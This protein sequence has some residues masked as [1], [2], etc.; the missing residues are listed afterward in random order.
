MAKQKGIRAGRAFVEIFADNNKLIRGLRRARKRLIAFGKNIVNIASRVTAGISAIFVPL[1]VLTIKAAADAQESLSRF[2]AVFKNQAEA[3]K[4]FAD[5]LAEAVG[6]SKFDIIDALSTFQSFFVGLGFSN[7]G[8]LE[9][10]KQ[11][12]TL[13][14]DFASF[15][16]ITDDES[17]GRFISALSGSSEV[18]DR[19]GINIKQAAIQQELLRKGIEKSASQITEQEKAMARLGIITRAMGDQ[20][21]IG[22]AIRTAG[23]FTNQM[24]RLKG[25]IRDTSVAIGQALLPIVTP[26]LVKIT[27]I[28]KEFGKWIAANK[29]LVATLFKITAAIVT[30]GVGVILIGATIAG[31]GLLLGGVITAITSI[32][33]IMTT[34]ATAISFVLTP[35]GLVVIA[36]VALGV[37]IVTMTDVGAEALHWLGER[38]RKLQHNVGVV[39]NGIIDAFRGGDIQLAARIL[40]LGLR[41]VWEIGINELSTLWTKFK[42]F[43]IATFNA[44]LD[45]GE[46]AWLRFNNVLKMDMINLS[47]FIQSQW[48]N[49][50]T[51]LIELW[52]VFNNF[53]TKQW[54]SLFNLFGKLTDEQLKAAQALSDSETIQK[55][56]EIETKGTEKDREIEARLT[57]AQTTR[58][59][60]FENKLGRIGERNLKEL[61]RLDEQ[62]HKQRKDGEN[63]I[64]ALVLRLE[65]NLANARQKA[66]LA[67]EN[68]TDFASRFKEFREKLAGLGGGGSVTTK[69]GFATSGL[70]KF[71]G[72]DVVSRIVV[73]IEKIER[74]TKEIKDEGGITFSG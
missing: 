51:G 8:A 61:T 19:F 69:S 7:T 3:A 55:L 74:N 59:A 45:G 58:Q 40:W 17:V 31:F 46:A 25:V 12:Q 39:V 43:F 41:V 11:L 2:E 53:L 20:G 64:A 16:N 18:L 30:V 60:K 47:G 42:H 24:K 34:M 27:K 38:F 37:A 68:E 72:G 35:I 21:A 15:N 1:S 36:V 48:N 70:L 23:S 26:I 56:V 4:K 13:A 28:V 49:L 22:D 9:L 67:A 50:L 65:R 29:K 73:G 32:G 6:R 33:T 14:L 10:S 54:L 44:I 62:L 63:E 66:K 5:K 57:A 71:Q 52:T